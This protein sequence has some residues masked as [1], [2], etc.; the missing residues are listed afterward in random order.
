MTYEGGEAS[1]NGE[2]R[3]ADK[4]GTRSASFS[5]N[6][7]Y[8]KTCVCGILLV[9]A[10]L[11]RFLTPSAVGRFRDSAVR[12]VMGNVDYRS[13][14]TALGQAMGGEKKLSEAL[15]EAYMYAFSM[16][17][18]EV[19]TSA[20]TK[21]EPPKKTETALR[22]VEHEPPADNAED[23]TKLQEKTKAQTPPDN[24]QP[25]QT[26]EEK[27]KANMV[28]AFTES[29]SSYSDIGLPENVTYDM[30]QLPADG[31]SP[32]SGTVS[33][34]FGYREHPADG[35]VRFHYGTDIAAERGTPVKAYTD[36]SVY[37]VGE[38]SGY[39][40]Y[41]ILEHENGMQT[42]Y[43]H[44]DETLVS[45]GETVTKGENIGKVGATGN[46]TGPCLHFE[47]IDDGTYVNPEYYISW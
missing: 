19:E 46:A 37:A 2:E 8:I 25:E 42:M 27:E 32:V 31:I 44:L 12:A 26:D 36:G 17:G 10:V 34:G 16:S 6:G 40:L 13:A 47:I 18:G 1:Y 4:D 38:S 35:Q 15:R 11:L 45:G 24:A 14:V 22:A 39:G 33:S 43:A 23:K 28:S 29:Q 41:V 21:P 5:S 7:F 20:E 30:P 3:I 9:L